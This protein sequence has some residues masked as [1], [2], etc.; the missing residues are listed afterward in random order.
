MSGRRRVPSQSVH[1]SSLWISRERSRR[2]NDSVFQLCTDISHI[3][4]Q[5]SRQGMLYNPVP[6]QSSVFQLN[7]AVMTRGWR[8]LDCTVC[9]GCGT[10][11]DESKLL[12][13]DECDVSYHIYHMKPPLERIPQGPYRCQWCSR[14]R[15]CNHK[16]TSGSELNS[17]GIC[18]PC[19]SLHKCPRCDKIYQLT[20]K[21]IRCSQCSK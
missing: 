18:H 21:I 2:I 19:A 10:G 17:A 11:G 4:R 9:E 16:V 15:R 3:L 1:V 13:C 6:H 7:S 5:S 20:E 14:C 8:C 12:L